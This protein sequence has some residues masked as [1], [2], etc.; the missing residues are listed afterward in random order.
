[1][2]R[3][4]GKQF[5]Q[6]N[7]ACFFAALDAGARFY[8]GYPITPSSEI[9]ELAARHLPAAGGV[10]LQ[11]ED[12]I[13]S[14]AAIIGASASGAKSF[15]ATSGPGFSLMQ[16]N[17]GMAIYTEVPCVIINIQRN[18]PSTG[19]ATRPG[20]GDVMQSRW[21]THGDHPIVVLS[22][23]SVQECYDLTVR[24]FNLSEQ[25]RIPVILL[26]DEVI[27]HMRESLVIPELLELEIVNRKVPSVPTEGYKAFTPEGDDIPAIPPFGT[28]HIVHISSSCHDESGFSHSAPQ[29]A[30]KLV[31]RLHRK[32]DNHKDDI[33]QTEWFGPHDAAVTIIAYGA[34]SRAAKQAIIEAQEK[35]LAVNLLRL[36][37]HWPFP[38]EQVAEALQKAKA[39]IVP[40]LNLGQV[41]SEVARV[42]SFGTA[43]YSVNRVDGEVILPSQLLQKI[44]EVLK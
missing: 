12:E 42:N 4:V 7:E 2:K 26:G 40:E 39:V 16:E 17:I 11:M 35:G 10:Y 38:E 29:T 1:M 21:G 27:G 32:I 24:A 3:P 23:A 15:T 31:R 8:G 25:Y 6:G 18:G 14:I 13:G 44:E 28:K 36:I 30:D 33:V 41:A 19:L 43:I 34:V 20:Q 37:T 22:P 9:A 5:M